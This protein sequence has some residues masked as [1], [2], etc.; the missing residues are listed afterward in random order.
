MDFWRSL[1][2][3]LLKLQLIIVQRIKDIHRYNIHRRFTI[4]TYICRIRRCPSSLDMSR[5]YL[6]RRKIKSRSYYY[7]HRVGCL[8][9]SMSMLHLNTN[10]FI[11][12]LSNVFYNN[13][14]NL[15][16]CITMDIIF[17]IMTYLK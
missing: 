16:N 14:D 11:N 3:S 7:R 17:I 10:K 2:N 15:I 6:S 1:Q 5:L 13:F 4:L 12:C 9:S 8:F